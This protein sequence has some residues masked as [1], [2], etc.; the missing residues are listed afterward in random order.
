MIHQQTWLECDLL[1]GVLTF[2]SRG[3]TRSRDKRKPL[4]L[5]YQKFRPPNLSRWK[6]YVDVLQPIKSLDPLT[7]WSYEITRPTKTIISPIPQRLW[8]PILVGWWLKW[9]PPI[10]IS[11][12]CGLVRSLSNSNL[13]IS[14]IAV[15]MTT[16]IG[17]VLI[18]LEGLN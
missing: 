16:K 17:R 3:L 14:T 7:T 9:L 13:Y 8:P 4:H 10:K 12:L 15:C 11:R 5:H 6:L 1:W 18:Y 2:W